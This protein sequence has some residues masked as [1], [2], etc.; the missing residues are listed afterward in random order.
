MMHLRIR[1]NAQWAGWVTEEG[2]L[3]A[4]GAIG[5]TPVQVGNV[6]LYRLFTEINHD[7][8]ECRCK[9]IEYKLKDKDPYITKKQLDGLKMQ[10]QSLF[11]TELQLAS[12]PFSEEE[13]EA[14]EKLTANPPDFSKCSKELLVDLR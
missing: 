6:T 9:P 11:C 10:L 7:C 8:I 5:Y 3:T 4:Y 13:L 1:G 14:L 2:Y 12:I